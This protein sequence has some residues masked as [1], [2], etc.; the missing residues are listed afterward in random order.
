MT[1]SLKRSQ[2]LKG[3]LGAVTTWCMLHPIVNTPAENTAT[4]PPKRSVGSR[5]PSKW[6]PFTAHPDADTCWS[7]SVG[8][9]GR[10]YA[11]ACA[12]GVPGGEVKVVRYNERTDS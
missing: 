1:T 7:L 6:Y 3:S 12:E 2:F 10:I 8:P 5:Y 9:D 4:T 11:A